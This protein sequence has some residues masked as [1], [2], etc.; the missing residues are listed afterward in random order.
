MPI[1]TVGNPAPVLL[2]RVAAIQVGVISLGALPRVPVRRKRELLKIFI[3]ETGELRVTSSALIP[4]FAG[5]SAGLAA[6][7]AFLIKVEHPLSH[8][9]SP[10]LTEPHQLNAGSVL[11]TSHARPFTTMPPEPPVLDF[12]CITGSGAPEA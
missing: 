11:L 4:L 9:D 5:E 7:A 12:S 3:G 1:H 8:V 2:P 10:L 6:N